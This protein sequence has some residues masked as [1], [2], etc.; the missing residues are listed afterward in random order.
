MRANEVGPYLE[1]SSLAQLRLPNYPGTAERVRPPSPGGGNGAPAVHQVGAFPRRPGFTGFWFSPSRPVGGVPPSAPSEGFWFGRTGV[2]PPFPVPN[3]GGRFE[4]A[5]EEDYQP[6]ED[7]LSRE[8]EVASPR[9]HGGADFGLL[10]L[11]L[12]LGG[13]LIA[14]GLQHAYGLFHGAGLAGVA[15]MIGASGFKNGAVLARVVGGVE[16]GGGALLVLGFL[17]PLATA[18]LVLL[19]TNVV[20][21]KWH[22]GFF[23]P[24]FEFELLLGLGAL[25]LL[26]AGPGRVSLDRWAPW[27]RR[28]VAWGFGCLVTAA[29][30]TIAGLSALKH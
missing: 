14:H 24:G 4:P 8:R 17:T 16:L 10:L 27:C 5:P 18:A 12:A 19:M 3:N 13:T 11:R 6:E 25:A 21:A 28:P 22:T 2:T 15:Q 23:V 30:V 26:F 29:I 1:G 7:Y 9:W 20:I